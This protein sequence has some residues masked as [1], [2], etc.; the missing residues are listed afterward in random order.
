MRKHRLAFGLA[1]LGTVGCAT[2]QIQTPNLLQTASV[3]QVETLRKATE[4]KSSENKPPEEKCEW[5]KL[6]QLSE[7]LRSVMVSVRRIGLGAVLEDLDATPADLA[8]ALIPQITR[9]IGAF[10][11]DKT[12]TVGSVVLSMRSG[13]WNAAGDLRLVLEQ[14][15]CADVVLR[16][17]EVHPDSTVHSLGNA[18]MDFEGNVISGASLLQPFDILSFRVFRE[19]P[20]PK[21]FIIANNTQWYKKPSKQYPIILNWDQIHNETLRDRE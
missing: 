3:G 2:P 8:A 16:V 7:E 13:D 21:I 9:T 6:S 15:N 11:V 12:F 19:Y 4:L 10:S 1:L 20:N 17:E 18:R 5:K 14:Y